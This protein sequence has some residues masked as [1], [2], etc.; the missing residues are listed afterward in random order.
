MARG[1]LS[2][3]TW[4][5]WGR[6]L[7]PAALCIAGVLYPLAGIVL[8]IIFRVRKAGRQLV[9]APLLGAALSLVLYTVNFFIAVAL[10]G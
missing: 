5:R 3:A 6:R 9:A 4:R 10:Q 7:A 1:G 8:G 2:S